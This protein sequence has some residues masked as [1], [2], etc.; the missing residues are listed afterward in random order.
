MSDLVAVPMSALLLCAP[1]W[2]AM[3]YRAL[4]TTGPASRHHYNYTLDGKRKW[5]T[6]KGVNFIPPSPIRPLK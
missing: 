2:I 5:R 3:A 1:V 4:R 6:Q